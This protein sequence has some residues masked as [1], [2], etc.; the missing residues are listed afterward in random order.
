MVIILGLPTIMDTQRNAR[1]LVSMNSIHTDINNIFSSLL[2][3]LVVVLYF[4]A[5]FPR[6]SR[7][8]FFQNYQT[9]PVLLHVKLVSDLAIMVYLSIY[10][11][12]SDEIV[13]LVVLIALLK[14][15]FFILIPLFINKIGDVS[16]Q[17]D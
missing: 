15:Q 10:H 16:L 7:K 14:E 4:Y 6:N 17:L 2:L 11:L 12:E 13:Q 3:G 1:I 8:A 9:R 5:N